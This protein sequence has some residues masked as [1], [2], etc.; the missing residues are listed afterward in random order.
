MAWGWIHEQWNF[1]FELS[2]MNVV[3][4]RVTKYLSLAWNW[5]HLWSGCMWDP[6][7][8]GA[9]TQRTAR[10]WQG[11]A[12]RCRWLTPSRQRKK[13]WKNCVWRSAGRLFQTETS[14]LGPNLDL[15][16]LLRQDRGQG[17]AQKRSTKNRWWGG[18]TKITCFKPSMASW[19]RSQWKMW[20]VTWCHTGRGGCW[21]SQRDSH[22]ITAVLSPA[23]APT[24]ATETKKHKELFNQQAENSIVVKSQSGVHFSAHQ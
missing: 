16:E 6:R 15:D 5:T 2:F 20:A 11:R 1:I 9:E 22:T 19:A 10:S 24:T 21:H 14:G 7:S 12:G 17:Q 23:A 13:W 8:G 3:V 4:F 18:M